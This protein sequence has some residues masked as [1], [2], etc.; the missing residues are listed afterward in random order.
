MKVELNEGCYIVNN[1]KEQKES[2]LAHLSEMGTKSEKV[3]I[4]RDKKEHIKEAKKEF[5][6][7]KSLNTPL[8]QDMIAS[9]GKARVPKWGSI[10]VSF[11]K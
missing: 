8:R 3:R 11:F 4:F 5:S 7:N 9:I 6:K 10:K 2:M 1:S